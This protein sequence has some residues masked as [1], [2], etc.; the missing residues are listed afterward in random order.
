MTYIASVIARKGV[1]IIAD[2]LVTSMHRVIEEDTLL[3]YLKNKKNTNNN[4]TLTPSELATLF[5][6]KP[7]HTKDFENKLYGYDKYTAIT[8]SGMAWLDN[9]KIEE[10]IKEAIQKIT[11]VRGYSHQ[12]IETKIKHLCE[13]LTEKVKEHLNIFNEVG[14]TSFILTHYDRKNEK[15][16]IYRIFIYS[17]N[18]KNLNDNNYQFVGYKKAED[19]EK[20]VCDGQNRISERILLGDLLTTYTLIPKICNKIF[21]EFSINNIPQDYI[22]KVKLDPNIVPL[23]IIDGAKLFSL[24]D[25]SLQQAVDLACLLMN[26]EIDF[27]KYTEDIPTVGGVVKLAIIDENG[28]RYIAGIEIIKP[29]NI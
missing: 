9:M 16:F 3:N 7:S 17:S 27:Q 13:F 12:K 20:V 2:S 28:F 25:L 22:E 5:Q 8:T 24:S 10:I 21:T 26:I 29:N 19:Y 23:S 18:K 14:N 1:A 6:K 4:I 15:T 11:K